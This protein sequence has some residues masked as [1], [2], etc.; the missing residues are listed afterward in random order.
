MKPAV[1]IDAAT[2]RARFVTGAK[3][4]PSGWT[5]LA[6]ADLLADFQRDFEAAAAER[7]H[8]LFGELAVHAGL[9]DDGGR[10]W[11]ALLA[12]AFGTPRLAPAA[13]LP[14]AKEAA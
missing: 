2:G 4:P 6:L 5:V 14:A 11:P 7:P 12:V 13:G 9:V 3:M 1:E 10:P 8:I